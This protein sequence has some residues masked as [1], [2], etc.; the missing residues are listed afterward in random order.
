MS[1][2]D[3]PPVTPT[4]SLPTIFLSATVTSKGQVTLPIE[5]RRR[6]GIERGSKIEIVLNSTSATIAAELPMRS[7]FGVLSQLRG[8]DT[9]I[10]KEPDRTFHV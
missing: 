5:M 8:I 7:G 1:P 2:I 10:P 4:T 3:L 6:L 9:T